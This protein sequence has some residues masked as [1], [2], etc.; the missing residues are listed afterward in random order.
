MIVIEET[1]RTLTPG[2]LVP[3]V[4]ASAVLDALAD[5]ET[6]SRLLPGL[7]DGSVTAGVGLAGSVTVNDGIGLGVTQARF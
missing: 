6:K 7:A 1:G 3:T 2:P 4:I 5:D